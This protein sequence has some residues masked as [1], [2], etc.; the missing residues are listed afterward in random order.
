MTLGTYLEEVGISP[1]V[2]ASKL[3]MQDGEAQIDN[4]DDV[5]KANRMDREELED[6]HN[7]NWDMKKI[8]S[9]EER[10]KLSRRCFKNPVPANPGNNLTF[11]GYRG[12]GKYHAKISVGSVAI[13][14][15]VLEPLPG[16]KR[17]NREE[18]VVK[19]DEK[20]KK[21]EYESFSRFMKNLY[22][23]KYRGQMTGE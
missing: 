15:G 19:R 1:E 7:N 12:R 18:D 6:I 14:Q 10:V 5:R 9:D 21:I 20:M 13:K 2:D 16:Y 8:N 17:K 22:Y 23:K 3:M 11:H 4:T